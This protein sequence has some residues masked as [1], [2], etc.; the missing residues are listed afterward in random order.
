MIH[1]AAMFASTGD[2]DPA[3]TTREHILE[4]ILKRERRLWNEV[5]KEKG[6]PDGLKD[7]PIQQAAAYL[8]LV[9]V[10]EGITSKDRAAELLENC[11]RL[12]GT[13]AILRGDIAEIF[14][15]LYPGPGWVNGVTP[16]LVGAYLLAQSEDDFVTGF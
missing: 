6:L 4:L 5:I 16:D 9:S 15:E 1:A 10:N 3:L 8:T 11:S 7:Q 2:L 14:H 12:V 13:D